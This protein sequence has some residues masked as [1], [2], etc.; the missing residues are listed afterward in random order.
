MRI[1]NKMAGTRRKYEKFPYLKETSWHL[2]ECEEEI[3][4]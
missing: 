1:S 4:S 2:H 3:S